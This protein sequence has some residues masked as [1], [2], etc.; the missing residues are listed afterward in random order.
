MKV[1]KI[2]MAQ[3]KVCCEQR[4]HWYTVQKVPELLRMSFGNLIDIRIRPA[5]ASF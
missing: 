5:F 3:Q 2:S 4:M 1:H